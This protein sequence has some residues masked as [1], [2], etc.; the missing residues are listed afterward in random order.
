MRYRTKKKLVYVLII[1]LPLLLGLGVFYSVSTITGKSVEPLRKEVR[2]DPVV[3]GLQS[4]EIDALSIEGYTEIEVEALQGGIVLRDNC[5]GVPIA[6]SNLKT[7]SIK[8]GVE[9]TLD[10]RPNYH[11]IM[12]DMLDHYESEVVLVK[13]GRLKNNFYYADLFLEQEGDILHIDSRPSD[14]LGMASRFDA[15][16][17]VSDALLE[18]QGVD[19]CN[20]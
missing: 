20:L 9:N 18:K 1:V 19:V 17:Y 5:T 3:E 11:D 14:A 2:I 12:Y 15:P 13:V 4:L 8:R 16:I 6:M 10:I 7:F